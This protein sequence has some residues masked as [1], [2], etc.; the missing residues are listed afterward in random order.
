MKNNLHYFECQCSDPEHTLRFTF[1]DDKECPMV[2]ASVFLSECPWYQ[3]IWKAFKY[4][5]GYKCAYGHFQECILQAKD[6]DR[7]IAIIE[8]LKQM[9]NQSGS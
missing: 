6:A 7:L 5:F 1:D 4:I 9:K 2:Y 3:R 8:K